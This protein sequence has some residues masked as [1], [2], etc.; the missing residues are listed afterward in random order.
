MV[1]DSEKVAY[2]LVAF[3]GGALSPTQQQLSLSLSLSCTLQVKNATNCRVQRNMRVTMA[4]YRS[5]QVQACYGYMDRHMSRSVRTHAGTHSPKCVPALF[6]RRD[7]TQARVRDRGVDKIMN[8]CC[9]CCCKQSGLIQGTGSTAHIAIVMKRF[10]D[11][12]AR[13]CRG[14]PSWRKRR[15]HVTEVAIADGRGIN[16]AL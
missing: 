12:C 2:Y 5:H 15:E 1:A 3:C 10:Q 16:C 13:N 6:L 11:I 14:C 7:A 9:C 4:A 8:F